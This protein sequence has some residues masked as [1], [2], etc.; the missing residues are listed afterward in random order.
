MYGRWYFAHPKFVEQPQPL[1]LSPQT[2]LT[3]QYRD[4]AELS[5]GGI[6]SSSELETL[7]RQL[8]AP[9]TRDAIGMTISNVI[10]GRGIDSHQIPLHRL[11]SEDT[12]A[13]VA[14]SVLDKLWGWLKIFGN[15]SSGMV[16]VYLLWK[17]FKYMLDIIVN[18]KILFDVFGWSFHLLAS[19]S[20]TVS[21]YLVHRRN[22]FNPSSAEQQQE[23]TPLTKL[24]I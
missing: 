14:Q 16:G 9:I 23:D 17:F 24:F 8:L 19:I 1:E 21:K 15:V 12:I 2:G 6:Y 10:D 20:T 4:A 13:T 18:S 5:E 3:W 11:I 22:R 7:R